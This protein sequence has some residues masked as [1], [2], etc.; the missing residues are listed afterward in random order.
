VSNVVKELHSY[1]VPEIIALRIEG[2][3]RDYLKWITGSV[4]DSKVASKR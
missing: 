4:V 2:G 3:S 1:E